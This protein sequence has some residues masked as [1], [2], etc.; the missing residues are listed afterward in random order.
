MVKISF[1]LYWLLSAVGYAPPAGDVDQDTN[2]TSAEIY[3][4]DSTAIQN[5]KKTIS[6]GF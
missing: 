3:P 1:I 2:H 5:G 4:L 6:N